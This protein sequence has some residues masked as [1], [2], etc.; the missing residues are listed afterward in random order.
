M[1][2]EGI[3]LSLANYLLEN[4][5]ESARFDVVNINSP[6][7]KKKAMEEAAVWKYCNDH[8]FILDF[9]DLET[10]NSISMKG[11]FENWKYTYAF[12]LWLQFEKVLID[13][14]SKKT[15]STWNGF[16]GGIS[17]EVISSWFVENYG[18]NVI[19]EFS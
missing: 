9:D 4:N 18:I 8:R 3:T 10:I 15:K 12:K 7:S 11:I 16:K 2:T 19:K 5:I 1:I 13:P 14:E 6:E 17:I